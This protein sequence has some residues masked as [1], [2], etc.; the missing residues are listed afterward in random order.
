MKLAT[1]KVVG[2]KIVVEG[3]PLKE[4]ST[5]TL[6]AR[7]DDED[8]ELGPHEEAL[9]LETTESVKRGDFVDGDEFLRKLQ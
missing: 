6:L 1:G 5:V 8:F 2:G 7:E 9:L 3:E 4:G